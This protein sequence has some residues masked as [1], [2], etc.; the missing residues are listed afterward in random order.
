MM[1]KPCVLRDSIDKDCRFLFND[2]F[3]TQI[4]GGMVIYYIAPR[5]GT[6]TA[7]K[8][9]SLRSITFVYDAISGR[10]PDIATLARAS[11]CLLA[12]L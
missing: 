8:P 2:R 1:I 12:T 6:V 9:V 5:K 11:A 10:M 3:T 4:S 7:F